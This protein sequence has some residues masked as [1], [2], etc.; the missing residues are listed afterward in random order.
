[1]QKDIA[2]LSLFNLSPSKKSMLGE[3]AWVVAGQLVIALATLIGVRLLTE[4]L[5][6][7]IYGTL[8]LVMGLTALGKGLFCQPFL[9]AAYRLHPDLNSHGGIHH[10]RKIITKLLTMTT[11]GLVGLILIGGVVY[12][13]F[14]PMSYLVFIALA[15]CLVVEILVFQ[16]QNYLAAARRQKA[17]AIWKCANACLRP[18]LAVSVILVLGATPQSVLFGY[19][20][21]TGL[22]LLCTRLLPFDLE[23]KSQSS[24]KDIKSPELKVEILR[25]ALPLMPLA[26]VGW[27]T[28]ASDRY[29]IGGLLGVAQVGIY[30]AAYGL[31]S[32]PLGMS[33]G[34]ITQTLRPVH[35]QAVSANNEKLEKRVFR[36]WLLATT[37]LSLLGVSAIILLSNWIAFFCLAEEYRS[38]ITLF[39][40]LASGLA[41]LT[42]AHVF[43]SALYAFKFTKSVLLGQSL[44]AF[45]AIAVTIPMILYWGLVGAA[46]ACPLYYSIYC[47]IMILLWR[48]DRRA[49]LRTIKR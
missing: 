17:C 34:V 23:G 22:T 15:G 21:A 14:A 10:L 38:S 7:K 25:Y 29:I 26:L 42:V 47:L 20:A 11:G 1:M 43:E 31:I 48:R 27:V 3:G 33:Y 32:K 46:M 2:I 28:A 6:P 4:F 9:Q 8:A 39:P 18:M 12:C 16:E 5:P 37:I 41:L 40:W 24:E 35:N 36:S 19:F 13:A 44:A 45:F 30:S 49:W